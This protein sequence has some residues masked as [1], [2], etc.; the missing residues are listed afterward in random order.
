MQV[1]DDVALD[2]E[3]LRELAVLDGEWLEAHVRLDHVLPGREALALRRLLAAPQHGLGHLR[4]GVELLHQGRER[5]AVAVQARAHRRR[6]EHAGDLG[7]LSVGE[8][9]GLGGG[10]GVDDHDAAEVLLVLAH[11]H[12]LVDE[13]DAA[14][15]G[16][17][18]GRRLHVLAVAEHDGVLGAARDEHVARGRVDATEVARVEVAL[19]VDGRARRLGVALVAGHDLRALG[20]D[21]ADLARRHEAPR[22]RVH[23]AQARAP[24]R[25]AD[26][27]RQVAVGGARR[28]HGRGLRQ[29]VAHEEF[30][31]GVVEE[32]L[33]VPR[34]RAA[35]AE[36]DL[37]LAA[38]AG[39]HL[40]P[41]QDVAHL[42]DRQRERGHGRGEG[43]LKDV[44]PALAEHDALHGA[45]ALDVDLANGVEEC[46]ELLRG[47][48]LL[49][50]GVLHAVVDGLEEPR[51]GD[52]ELR[53]LRHEVLL[54]VPD[55]AVD[56]LH[57][58]RERPVL[59]RA[60]EDVPAGEDGHEHVAH[61]GVLWAHGF[62]VVERV[63][64]D[65]VH[66]VAVLKHH[67][68]RPRRRAAGVHERR[69]RLLR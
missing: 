58:A 61:R 26:A 21:D 28:D 62:V 59:R 51:H 20:R 55:V 53:L 5:R 40:G 36:H 27:A 16:V 38:E 46:H 24:R 41:D 60:L 12:D 57:A 6:A 19:R 54:E 66:E 43:A 14:D 30:K 11:E 50:E 7:R 18:D 8:E 29:A 44:R 42:V 39:A 49:A 69:R 68:L 32:L 64:V 45:A 65:L 17:L 31:V 2:L 48:A 33:E 4:V 52:E 9:A 37:D 1:R 23:D 56:H 67:A 47:G 63:L 15:D 13:V 10:L 3:R 25:L 34:E 22:L 35:A